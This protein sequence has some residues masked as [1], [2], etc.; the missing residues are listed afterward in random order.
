M[1]RRDRRRPC[2]RHITSQRRVGPLLRGCADLGSD[3]R[4]GPCNH[5]AE[6]VGAGVMHM[7]RNRRTSIVLIVAAALAAASPALADRLVST[8][9]DDAANDCSVLPCRTM[10][11]AVAVAG[12]GETIEIARGSYLE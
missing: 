1:C 6:R 4:V 11:K 5:R 8:L 12:D 10:A 7:K 9:G 2:D 3:R